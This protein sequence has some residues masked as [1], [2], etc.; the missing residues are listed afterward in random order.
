MIVRDVNYTPVGA[1][2]TVLERVNLELPPTGLNLI[3]GR[4][5]FGKSTLLSLVSGLAEPT[6]GVITFSDLPR[7]EHLPAPTV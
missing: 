3:V 4:S 1:G 7:G 6:A 2:V 5:G